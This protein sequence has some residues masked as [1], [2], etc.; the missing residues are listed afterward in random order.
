MENIITGITNSTE[1]SSDT[2]SLSK[3]KNYQISNRNSYNSN[4]NNNSSSNNT[5][6]MN[7]DLP[8]E[9]ND[10]HSSLSKTNND[11]GN[12]G[13]NNSNSYSES[14][15]QSNDSEILSTNNSNHQNSESYQDFRSSQANGTDTYDNSE[16]TYTHSG[17]NKAEFT[18]TSSSLPE[19][20]RTSSSDNNI[21][22]TS[23]DTDSFSNSTNMGDDG[24]VQGG[25]L[26]TSLSTT[27]SSTSSNSPANNSSTGESRQ[28]ENNLSND[29]KSSRNSGYEVG[30]Y[31][32]TQTGSGEWQIEYY[33]EAIRAYQE[34]LD[35]INKQIGPKGEVSE[36]I[37][38]IHR[39][40]INYELIDGTANYQSEI[41]KQLYANIEAVDEYIREISDYN[42]YEELMQS[43]DEFKK[44]KQICE[45]MITYYERQPQVDKYNAMMIEA[46]KRTY[47]GMLGE[48]MALTYSGNSK[49]EKLMQAKNLSLYENQLKE[50]FGENYKEMFA[51]YGLDFDFD[52][53][54]LYNYIYKEYGEK[55]AL[56]YYEF[57]EENIN[58][59]CGLV[60]ALESNKNLSTKE[61]WYNVA[62]NFL[63]VNLQGIS[64]GTILSV[65]GITK[66]IDK[67][68][69]K[70]ITDYQTMWYALMLET[71]K[72]GPDVFG[73]NL[74]SINYQVGQGTGQML[75]AMAVGA[76]VGAVCPFS[77]VVPVVGKV[78]SAGIASSFYM[79]ASTGGR[80][81]AEQMQNGMS[82]DKALIHG[83]LTGGLEVTTEK[84]LGGLSMFDHPSATSLKELF[85]VMA[86]EG[87]QEVAQDFI[88]EL[89]LG[90]GLPS[91]ETKEEAI[92][93]F[94]QKGMTFVVAALSAG[95]LEGGSTAVS[96]HNIN[97]IY[98]NY[99]NNPNIDVTEA[100]LADLIRRNFPQET[101]KM[102]DAEV[103][104][105][106]NRQ[107]INL[108]TRNVIQNQ[109]MIE[110]VANSRK[111]DNFHA[112]LAS[113]E[114]LT[115]HS[116]QTSSTT[117]D[118][119]LYT[120]GLI[121]AALTR[122]SDYGT[123]YSGFTSMSDFDKLDT[124][125]IKLNENH[126]LDA[127]TIKSYQDQVQT[128]KKNFVTHFSHLLFKQI[129]SSNLK[130]S[131]FVDNNYGMVFTG[132]EPNREYNLKYEY[133]DQFGIKLESQVIV[134]TNAQGY[135]L[136]QEF[137]RPQIITDDLAKGLSNGCQFTGIELS[138]SQI[139]QENYNALL[140]ADYDRIG[141]DQGVFEPVYGYYNFFNRIK[142]LLSIN[143]VDMQLLSEC[144]DI[145]K[146]YHPTLSDKDAVLFL[147]KI[148]HVEGACTYASVCNM[149]LTEF[150]D[151]PQLFKNIF[152]YD[153]YRPL[154]NGQKVLNSELLMADLYTF[155]NKD[156]LAFFIDDLR[157]KLG[158]KYELKTIY[159]N[160]ATPINQIYLSGLDFFRDDIIEEFLKYKCSKNNQ[161]YDVTLDTLELTDIKQ[162]DINNGSYQIIVYFSDN[163]GFRTYYINPKTGIM[164]NVYEKEGQ[165]NH[166][167]EIVTK[168]DT[169][170]YVVSWGEYYFIP[171]SSLSNVTYKIDKINID[172]NE[173]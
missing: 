164:D 157:K 57:Y 147:S 72:Y 69:E 17:D 36:L 64:D 42:S 85:V 114:S 79:F 131:Y 103:I 12:N 102:S 45:Q 34:L 23:S 161:S 43:L 171:Y 115:N 100:D 82:R 124:I 167:M 20:S 137:Y 61:E 121:Q 70:T 53:L 128:V 172:I 27:S 18:N 148:D 21:S 56:E 112:I 83:M 5:E 10:N 145:V 117:I 153:M 71:K 156:N 19:N 101:A 13:S 126:I 142:R 22:S 149:I 144:K 55:A 29:V 81:Y 25:S 4:S 150:K 122:A 46:K 108:L 59:I 106:Y 28:E 54:Q 92:E 129:K 31:D 99:I 169:G 105:Q 107:C 41:D 135:G 65:E 140:G 76:L 91:F 63:T 8:E 32:S 26:T 33:E 58:S 160:P 166:V 89:L 143:T 44:N 96:I 24:L 118:P 73:Y 30:E 154:P 110:K 38:Q 60:S 152:G 67:H 88:S 93:Y 95:E 9:V 138:G 52:Y 50:L 7:L 111:D 158:N 119:S 74:Q 16:A 84:L 141:I 113:L 168:S 2:G 87:G 62:S 159:R 170:I 127:K 151:D 97:D 80:D 40:F 37:L 15:Y 125:L 139:N 123:F 66:W 35:S 48:K 120:E 163:P 130:I 77:A 11:V 1:I 90:D 3:S 68:P 116:M 78:T 94:K 109:K 173:Q 75:P 162:I 165:F 155:A 86:K 98:N 47:D 133:T 6:E 132:L 134:R 14:S 39:K 146:E 51:Q 49:Y 136:I 104:G